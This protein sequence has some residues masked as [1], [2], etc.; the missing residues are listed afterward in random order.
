MNNQLYDM[1]SGQSRR[2]SVHS[3]ISGGSSQGSPPRAA[4]NMHPQQLQQM[5]MAKPSHKGLQYTPQQLAEAYR[6]QQQ[7]QHQEFMRQFAQM[8]PEEKQA[9]QLRRQQLLQQRQQQAMAASPVQ[10]QATGVNGLRYTPEQI[11]LHNQ[12]VAMIAQMS[13]GQQSRQRLQQQQQA[14]QMSPAQLQPSQQPSQQQQQQPRSATSASTPEIYFTHPINGQQYTRERF[15]QALQRATPEQQAIW[16]KAAKQ[17]QQQSR[18]AAGA[19]LAETYYTDPNNRRYTRAQFEEGLG[20][21][22]PENQA[23]VRQ[24]AEQQQQAKIAAS[25]S[26]AQKQQQQPTPV[27]NPADLYYTDGNGRQYTRD[28]FEQQLAKM[29]P[30]EA[31]HYRQVAQSQRQQS[32]KT[33]GPAQAQMQQPHL[34]TTTNSAEVYATDANGRTYTKEQFEQHLSTLPQERAAA[35][36]HKMQQQRQA[37]M[38][39]D[40]T[41]PQAQ[42]QAQAP[43]QRLMSVAGSTEVFFTDG[44]GRNYTEA[45]FEQQLAQAP[46]EQ[47]ELFRKKAQHQQEIRVRL[48]QMSPEQREEFQRQARQNMQKFQTQTAQAKAMPSAMSPQAQAAAKTSRVTQPSPVLPLVAGAERPSPESEDAYTEGRAPKVAMFAVPT[49]PA[50]PSSAPGGVVAKQK[51]K[52]AAKKS[53]VK[54]IKRR[55][56]NAVP[57]DQG[58]ATTGMAAP[59]KPASTPA[60]PASAMSP[61]IM[62]ASAM[63]K[64]K[65]KANTSKTIDPKTIDL[66]DA[67]NDSRPKDCTRPQQSPITTSPGSAKSSAIDLT[68]PEESRPIIDEAQPIAASPRT[69]VTM[70]DI[71]PIEREPVSGLLEHPRYLHA[72][73]NGVHIRECEWEDYNY[74]DIAHYSSEAA[75]IQMRRAMLEEAAGAVNTGPSSYMYDA[76]YT[77]D[78]VGYG[79]HRVEGEGEGRKGWEGNLGEQ[80]SEEGAELAWQMM[81]VTS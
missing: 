76:R 33:A 30:Q 9:F 53:Q 23:Q 49:P 28:L 43:P 50:R 52:T 46:V 80:M 55:H 47:A 60:V 41:Q 31:E 70:A 12:R 34:A 62:P 56:K 74:N 38:A 37:K 8:S 32:K 45:E 64:T 36:R 48:A 67:E 29:P 72:L 18:P 25:L 58:V 27:A 51:K 59:A 7:R 73:A 1:L 40:A 54:D 19:S 10:A 20:K 21:L 66:T 39:P 6:Q 35:I 17:Q 78:L 2:D 15:E 79:S 75:E 63:P 44:R 77:R 26:H 42:A 5:M 68:G 61:P 16:R 4:A 81:I 65:N 69:T 13:P 57:I 14:A 3:R 24:Q 71:A 22:S 11:Q